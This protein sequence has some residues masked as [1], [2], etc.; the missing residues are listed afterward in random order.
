MVA[1]AAIALAGAAIAGGALALSSGGADEAT[2]RQAEVRERGQTVMP[3]DLDRTTHVFRKTTTGGIQQVLADNPAD[4]RSIR[5]VR[6]HLRREQAKFRRGD[7]QDPMAIHGMTMPGIDEL[8][9]GAAAIDVDYRFLPA[10]AELRF[11][12]TDPGLRKA[13]HR[14]S[15][16]ALGSWCR[17]NGRKR[18]RVRAVS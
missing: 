10:G 2:Q 13:L 3:F 8:R 16:P 15:R 17:R 1:G 14:G 12:T 18:R 4:R 9:R 6:E 11:T 5:I 7:Y